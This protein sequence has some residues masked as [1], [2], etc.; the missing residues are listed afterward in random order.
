MYFVA[1]PIVTN[2]LILQVDPA[3]TVCY[4]SGSTTVNNLAGNNISGSLIGN[5][6]FTSNA[7]GSFY[8]DGSGD[9]IQTN[10]KLNNYFTDNANFTVSTWFNVAGGNAISSI[11]NAIENSSGWTMYNYYGS[12]RMLYYS[13]SISSTVSIGNLGFIPNNT[14]VNFTFVL[15]S[16]TVSG[17]YNGRLMTTTPITSYAINDN[18]TSIGAFNGGGAYSFFGSIGVSQIYN[19]ALTLSEVTQ[20]FNALKGRYGI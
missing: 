4:R 8:F 9:Y 7:L 19:R 13:S 11:G 6:T 20:N 15:N 1:Q 3:S 14:W 2:G 12:M 16:L 5:T 18:N 10:F 17:Y